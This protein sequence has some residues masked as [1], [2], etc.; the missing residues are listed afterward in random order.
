MPDPTKPL[1]GKRGTIIIDEYAFIPQPTPWARWKAASRE[2]LDWWAATLMRAL[3]IRP[4]GIC[5]ANVRPAPE[6]ANK[7]DEPVILL[8]PVILPD[9]S[10]ASHE[11]AL[12]LRA[13][14]VAVAF[15]PPGR[16]LG[17]T[18][19]ERL[20]RALK[21]HALQRSGDEA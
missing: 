16:L 10:I 5:T 8:D 4:R 3:Y 15:P 7:G 18:E 6:R 2:L 13:Q 12:R 19:A 1:S 17:R 11:L 9:N 21:S 14:G 20:A